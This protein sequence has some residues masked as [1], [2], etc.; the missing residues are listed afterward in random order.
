IFKKGDKVMA[1][2]SGTIS[3]IKAIDTYD[4]PIEE[5]YPGMS[6]TMLLEDDID[7]SRG[8]MLVREHNQ[9]KVEQDIEMMICWLNERK[10]V[11]GGKYLI[12][13]STQD[14]KCIVKDVQYKIN[15]NT[16]HRI[17]N[18]KEVKLNDVARISI[19][20][21]KPLFFDNYRKNRRTGSMILIDEATNET[22]GAG[23]IL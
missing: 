3:K 11:A 2:P 6:V 13:H 18:D 14:A 7:L 5:A 10:L 16:L 4:G 1:L 22:V 9:P 23:M 12:K 8:D 20:T 15:I 21:T 19:R 17:E